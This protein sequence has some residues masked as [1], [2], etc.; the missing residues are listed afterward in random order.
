MS[1]KLGDGWAPGVLSPL[2]PRRFSQGQLGELVG[3]PRSQEPEPGLVPVSLGVLLPLLLGSS[4]GSVII[5]PEPG[6]Q[7]QAREIQGRRE[8]RM[9]RA[10]RTQ[11]NQCTGVE[12]SWMAGDD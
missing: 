6:L 4:P 9:D 5:C 3:R 12:C 8:S 2:Q 1:R 11:P 10:S 7:G